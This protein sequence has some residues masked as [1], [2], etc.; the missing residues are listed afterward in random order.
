MCKSHYRN[1]NRVKVFKKRQ[2]KKNRGGKRSFRPHVRLTL[3]VKVNG[4]VRFT[5]LNL[6]L[7]NGTV[8]AALAVKNSTV[9][10]TETTVWYR[11]YTVRCEHGTVRTRWKIPLLYKFSVKILIFKFFWKIEKKSILFDY[12]YLM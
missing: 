1:C 6:R 4:S 7:K 9:H 3:N 10:L 2:R 11:H 12:G 5:L 8:T